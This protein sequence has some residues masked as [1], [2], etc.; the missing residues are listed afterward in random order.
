MVSRAAMVL[1]GVRFDGRLDDHWQVLE[2]SEL[3][4][5]PLGS[6][7]HLHSQ[8]PLFNLFLGLVLRLPRD[9]QVP[10]FHLTYLV[11]G[12]ALA[13]CLHAVFRRLGVAP[14][15]AVGLA[16]VVSVSPSVFLYEKWLHYDYPVTL[17]TC[18]AVLALQ[19]YEDGYQ[20]RH[21]ALFL[22]VIAALALT[23]SLFHLGWLAVWA[24]VLVLIRRRADWKRVAAVAVVPLVAVVAVYAN[25]WRVSGTF[26]PSTSLGASLA[27]ATTFQIPRAERQDLV[28]EGRLSALSL[29]DPYSPVPSY[30]GVVA[31]PDRTGVRVLD[32]EVKTASDGSTR[33]N[34]NNMTYVEASERY[35][36]DALRTIRIRPTAYARG[37]VTA[38]GLYFRPAGDY[39]ALGPNRQRVVALEKLYN[40]A[41]YG[42]VSGGEGSYSLPDPALH[43]RPRPGRTAWL[44]VL[45]HAVA[46]VGGAWAL[47][48]RRPDSHGGSPLVLGYLWSTLVYVMVVGNFVEVGENNRFRLYTEPLLVVLLAALAVRW[49]PPSGAAEGVAAS[50]ILPYERCPWCGRPKRAPANGGPVVRH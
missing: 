47:W 34:Y 1:A 11:V 35:L 20:L 4:A 15:V 38:F 22:G 26:A 39:F 48:R 3:R 31:R 32:D 27:K 24:A 43:Y 33:P 5:D 42:V 21:A 46:L 41:W 44:L 23:R 2:L 28:A 45:A 40:V 49:R 37:V 30:R 29:V 36:E 6:L 18:L 25:V 50:T 7:A 8:P 16:V 17:L 14:A 13:L 19:R 10:A 12:L 9:W